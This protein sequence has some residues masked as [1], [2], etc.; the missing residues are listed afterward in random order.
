VKKAALAVSSVRYRKTRVVIVMTERS[1]C[2]A[3]T[4]AIFDD[5][6][7]ILD[8]MRD[9]LTEEGYRIVTETTAD[10]ALTIVLRERPALVIL[11]F[12]MAD[13]AAGLQALRLIREHPETTTTPG[14]ICSADHTA[15]LD[16]VDD[17]RALGCE[18][19][20][21]PFGLYDLLERVSRLAGASDAP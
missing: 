10:D 12:W 9:T 5:D 6:V 11:D 14:L 3:G 15:L 16:Y 19:L 4:I 13:R 17:W 1:G 8:V 7:A 21:K 2:V 18:T 20:A